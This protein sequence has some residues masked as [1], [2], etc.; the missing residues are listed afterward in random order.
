[1]ERPKGIPRTE[2]Q[3]WNE[4][5]NLINEHC[6]LSGQVQLSQAIEQYK[7]IAVDTYKHIAI[8]EAR[9]AASVR[10]MFANEMKRLREIPEETTE[11]ADFEQAR[12]EMGFDPA[13]DHP[14]SF[15]QATGLA[16]AA[17]KIVREREVRLRAKVMELEKSSSLAIKAEEEM[18]QTMRQLVATI[19]TQLIVW[20]PELAE[21]IPNYKWIGN[22]SSHA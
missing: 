18:V 14:L 20:H 12:A 16:N 11:Q 6:Q 5:I 2:H 10:D 8:S 19:R 9:S 4:V 21:T 22:G 17:I 3:Q 7:E 1:M 13:F 15:K